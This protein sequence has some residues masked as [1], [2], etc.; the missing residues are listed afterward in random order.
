[1][2][3]QGRLLSLVFLVILISVAGCG[4]SSSS[5]SP[6]GIAGTVTWQGLGYPGVVMMLTGASSATATTDANGNYAFN[7][8]A[9]GNYT[10]S[11]QIANGWA[12]SPPSSAQA[13]AGTS[14]TGVNFIILSHP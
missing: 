7:N 4:G 5:S 8:L 10:V 11:P 13:I 3:L 6:Y 2:K 9:D 12:F 1:M 14:V